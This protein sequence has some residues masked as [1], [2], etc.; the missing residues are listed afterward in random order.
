MKHKITNFIQLT[1][2]TFF[3]QIIMLSCGKE[4]QSSTQGGGLF[5]I[6]YTITPPLQYGF[7][8]TTGTSQNAFTSVCNIQGLSGL[9]LMWY[10]NS[11]NL[12]FST[13][14]TN[15]FSVTKGQNVGIAAIQILNQIDYQCRT[16]KIEAIINGKVF[17]TITK[18]MGY[19]SSKP[20]IKCKDFDQNGVNFIMP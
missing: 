17:N 2:M 15:E 13:M 16:L 5:K 12:P 1:V 3:L 8:G 14:E 6:R 9:T 20:L 4:T 18:E 19:S 7:G 10:G 11:A